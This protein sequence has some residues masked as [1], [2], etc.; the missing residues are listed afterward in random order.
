MA[1]S[2]DDIP[3][4]IFVEFLASADSLRDLIALASI[5]SRA[6]L[7]FQHN[8]AHLVYSL[9][10]RQLGPLL[11]DA[12]ALN[13]ILMPLNATPRSE[14]F[15]QARNVIATYQQY[16]AG[17]NLPLQGRQPMPW[18][19]VLRFVK[20]YKVMRYAARLYIDSQM[21]LFKNEI[22]PFSSTPC[23]IDALSL[24]RTEHLRILRA[25]YRLQLCINIHGESLAGERRTANK[26]DALIIHY[27]LYR[28]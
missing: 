14:Y 16:L 25:F 13:D 3:A 4:E 22:N 19:G 1:I 5:S 12:L 23:T 8:K 21:V 18:D 2:L 6:H 10:S 28:L 7:I 11:P 17:Q 24:T 15:T 20:I 26:P 9:L 27:Y